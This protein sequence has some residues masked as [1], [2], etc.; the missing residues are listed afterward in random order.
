MFIFLC[1]MFAWSATLAG[2]TFP[3]THIVSSQTLTLN[4]MGL[5]EKFWIDIYVAALYLP[6]ESKNPNKVISANVPKRID[7][8]FIYSNVPKQ[9]MLNTFEENL[10]DNPQIPSKAQEEM[11]SC[12]NWFQD[13]TTGDSVSF[14]YEP[15]KG[16]TLFVNGTPKGTIAGLDFMKAVFT[17]YLGSKPASV[18]LRQALLGLN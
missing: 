17:I 1:S 11:R 15:E 8:E 4:G 9:K 2:V 16:T 7:I 18:P 6:F 12:Y 10:K 13:F 5:R 14:V 3:D